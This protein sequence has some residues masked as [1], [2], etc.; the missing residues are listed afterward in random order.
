MCNDGI[1]AS[2]EHP[3]KLQGHGDTSM[4]LAEKRGRFVEGIFWL[5]LFAVPLHRQ[6]DKK[7]GNGLTQRQ[8]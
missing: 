7:T 2:H 1:E 4:G 8:T 5:G 6:K 3:F